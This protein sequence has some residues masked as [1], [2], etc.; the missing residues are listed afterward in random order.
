MWKTCSLAQA[1][2]FQT[3]LNLRHIHLSQIV[4]WD[5]HHEQCILGCMTK[6]EYLAFKDEATGKYLKPEDAMEQGIEQTAEKP[7]TNVKGGAGEIRACCGVGLTDTGAGA[8]LPPFN[9]T[10]RWVVG[11]TQF[12]SHAKAN[13]AK[14][15]DYCS[16]PWCQGFHAYSQPTNVADKRQ[17]KKWEYQTWGA[18]V[19]KDMEGG[20]FQFAKEM[21]CPRPRMEDVE[22][23]DWR[24]E[25]AA[26]GDHAYMC[27]TE[28]MD[29]VCAATDEFHKGT[30]WEG[31][32]IIYHDALSAWFEPAAQAHMASLGYGPERQ[33]LCRG[34]TNFGTR[35]WMKL[36]GNR[37]LCSPQEPCEEALR[38]GPGEVQR[39]YHKATLE[40]VRQVLEHAGR[41]PREA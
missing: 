39:R 30:R 10:D 20:R 13:A 25:A 4:F 41:Q 9:Y 33:M 12:K 17:P 2:Q 11:P 6:F 18:A 16:G 31:K 1:E 22:P 35:Y 5:E 7:V 26:H 19:A 23:D 34:L 21:A 15:Q 28:I 3:E 8:G 37:H 36:V 38:H 24:R 29:H 27:V 14:V 40:R 32:S